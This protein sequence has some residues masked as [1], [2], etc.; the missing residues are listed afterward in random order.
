MST[1]ADPS[2]AADTARLAVP[3]R[4]RLREQCLTLLEGAGYATSML[5]GG[6]SI[7]RLD[8]LAFVEMRPRDAAAALAADQ[9]D[10]AFLSSDIV[11][12]HG[13]QQLPALPLGFSR[14][15]LV[16]A[17]RDDDDR[18]EVADLAG[19][20]VATHLPELT[21]AFFAEKGIEVTV[22]AMGGAL[23]GVCAAGLADAIV[24]L[25]ET[26]TSL[27]TNGLQVLEVVQACQALFVH[28]ATGAG[29]DDFTLRLEAVLSARGHRYVML[30]IGR[31]R[32]DDLRAILPGLAAPTVL[33]LTGR[34]DLVAVHLVIGADE[35]W[36]RLGELRA[37][38][39]SGIVALQPQALL[40]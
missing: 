31:D 11:R 39:A 10:A 24:D 37:L 30:H 35:L 27:M 6:G 19:G 17:S 4:G 28:R 18:H 21:R 13:L 23:E 20:V 36:D 40:G 22:V 1:A 8:G 14:S 33:P 2:A 15:D 26:G 29:L 3:S 25:R 32:L 5:H 9:L 38:G 12:E 34:D 7:A 16:V